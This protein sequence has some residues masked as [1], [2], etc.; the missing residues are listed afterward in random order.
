MLMNCF[1]QLCNVKY[2]LMNIILIKITP[3]LYNKGYTKILPF[4][5]FIFLINLISLSLS[6]PDVA[7]SVPF[8]QV[9]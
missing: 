6:S 8:L 5:F 1:V 9:L 2:V 3:T 7:N 4:V